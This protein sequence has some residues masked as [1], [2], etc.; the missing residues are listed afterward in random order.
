METDLESIPPSLFLS[1]LPT[2]TRR[3]RNDLPRYMRWTLKPLCSPYPPICPPPSP[4]LPSP[5]LNTHTPMLSC[6]PFSLQEE[7]PVETEV[8]EWRRRWW[9]EA[10]GVSL[11]AVM[12]ERK[13]K[14][15]RRV[16]VQAE[17]EEEKREKCGRVWDLCRHWWGLDSYRPSQRSVGLLKTVLL[18]LGY[19][20]RHKS[21]LQGACLG[22][23]V[24]QTNLIFPL[25]SN[26]FS[27]MH[28]QSLYLQLTLN[29]LARDRS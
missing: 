27:I 8:Q 7:V 22:F 9:R 16:D 24:N 6:P 20:K 18:V 28:S 14:K 21:L 15:K 17:E 12:G 11:P 29:V 25:S 23:T 2:H 5:L 1:F 13:G 19:E 26:S 4:V 3:G 10:N